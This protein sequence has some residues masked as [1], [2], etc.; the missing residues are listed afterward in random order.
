MATDTEVLAQAEVVKDRLDRLENAIA[1]LP[2][3]EVTDKVRR[4]VRRLHKQL[5]I[6][7]DMATEHFGLI[8]PMS[9]GGKPD[10][11]DDN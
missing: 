4:R 2:E 5:G 10:D 9:G 1:Q 6:A 11:E 3:G 8:T 7:L